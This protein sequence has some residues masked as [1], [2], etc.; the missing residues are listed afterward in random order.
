M[1][2]LD[3]FRFPSSVLRLPSHAPPKSP[4][5]EAQRT[6]SYKTMFPHPRFYAFPHFRISAFPQY[7]LRALGE[8]FASLAVK[9]ED[10]RFFPISVL[11]PQASASRAPSIPKRGGPAH[12]ELLASSYKTIFPHLR[13]P[14]SPHFRISAFALTRISAFPHSRIPAFPLSHISTSTFSS[15]FP[16]VAG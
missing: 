4:K 5:G 8:F 15:L 7:H 14:A 9:I 6:S 12:F 13:I 1:K 16:V 3:S 11:R 2:I 10:F